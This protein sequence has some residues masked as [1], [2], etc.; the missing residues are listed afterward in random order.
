[1]WVFILIISILGSIGISV[2][3]VDAI[4]NKAKI[5]NEPLCLIGFL[6]LCTLLIVLS[7]ETLLWAELEV[8]N[9]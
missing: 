9:L 8:S 1:M 6:L 2:F 4:E 3:L 7:Y 5:K